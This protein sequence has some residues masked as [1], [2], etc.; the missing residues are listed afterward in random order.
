[1]TYQIID[2]RYYF[3]TDAGTNILV[4]NNRGKFTKEYQ[5][6]LHREV[7]NFIP[8][9]LNVIYDRSHHLKGKFYKK[10]EVYSKKGDFKV[11][12]TNLGIKNEKNIL[13]KKTLSKLEYSKLDSYTANVKTRHNL[14]SQ[15]ASFEFK[16]ALTVGLKKYKNKPIQIIVT[17]QNNPKQMIEMTI[18]ND[19][20][21]DQTYK[22][23][24]NNVFGGDSTYFYEGGPETLIQFFELK[25]LKKIPKNAQ[26]KNILYQ[27][28]K[29][30]PDKHC[31]I[32][33]IK[34]YFVERINN[35]CSKKVI[36]NLTNKINKIKNYEE[37]YADGIPEDHIQKFVDDL[38]INIKINLPLQTSF[39]EFRNNNTTKTI[40]NFE[41]VNL[42][43]NHVD[44]L[45][46][47]NKI[48]IVDRETLIKLKDKLVSENNYFEIKKDSLG[49]TAIV[50][51]N[52]TYQIDNDFKEAMEEFEEDNNIKPC[53]L[54]NIKDKEV[55]KFIRES[56][57]YA[58]RMEFYEAPLLKLE[59]VPDE[60]FLDPNYDFEEAFMESKRKFIKDSVLLQIDQKKSYASYKQCKYFDGVLGKPTDWRKTDKVEGVGSYR[61]KNIDLSNTDSKSKEIFEKLNWFYKEDPVYDSI[62]LKLLD[63]ENVK[64]DI[65]EGCWG[66]AIDIIFTKD[67]LEKK[68][69]LGYNS[70]GTERKVS[71]YAKLCGLYNNDKTYETKIVCC[72]IKI[73]QILVNNLNEMNIDNNGYNET[74]NELYIF[75]PKNIRHHF[76]QF[77]AKVTACT[78]VNT[79]VQLKEMDLS[80]VYKISSDA[81]YYQK[82]D[83]KI[84]EPYRPKDIIIST[85]P[86]IGGAPCK[87]YLSWNEET[88]TEAPPSRPYY[89]TELHIGQGGGGKTTK[90]LLDKGLV[91][92]LYIAP[93]WKLACDKK[94]EF[95]CNVA[96]LQHLFSKNKQVIL[97]I[98]QY[99]NV[100]IID[101]I[102]QLTNKQKEHILKEYPNH[103]II[104]CGDI[105]K[106]G[107]NYQL[108]PFE[109]GDSEIKCMNVEKI[110]NIVEHSTNYRV[111][112]K[113]LENILLKLREMIQNGKSRWEMISYVEQIFKEHNKIIDKDKLKKLYNIEDMIISGTK[114]N[115]KEISE[116]FKG[117]FDKE[118]YY[119]TKTE[120]NAK[121]NGN[122]YCKGE[123][124]ISEDPLP[125]NISKISH[126]FTLH[127]LQGETAKNKLFIDLRKIECFD[128]TFIYTALSR[129]RKFKD[130]YLINEDAING[131]C[132]IHGKI[133]KISNGIDNYVGSTKQKTIYNRLADH[134][135]NYDNM[136]N[137]KPYD[138]CTVFKVLEKGDYDITLLEEYWCD[139]ESELILK[140]Y[141]YIQQI[142][143]VNKNGKVDEVPFI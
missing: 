26:N 108:P 51:P 139:T 101:E 85:G 120:K 106:E 122:G 91:R 66:D 100:L 141:E 3:T 7:I 109:K 38:N 88:A 14:T 63:A 42:R 132:K 59:D 138:K 133:Y 2:K 83:F 87:S 130:I 58:G 103:K 44:Y 1:M 36:D 11:K 12:F 35:S 9:S 92:P 69:F 65:Y 80:K 13:V 23:I 105:S 29:D 24:Y 94:K 102:S 71:Y 52:I 140:E 33:P 27:S 126:C 73:A 8:S 20:S 40:K 76:S 123:I 107:I 137:N 18:L 30:S 32:Q 34:D 53:K 79:F 54:C 67:M 125:E 82:H 81:I 95:N 114:L 21:L 75:I 124:H 96:V 46:S 98:N 61:I 64:Y 131:S 89:K 15:N 104:F 134:I 25:S 119:I 90:N 143:C 110:D 70:D 39:L 55:S 49:I 68:E 41:Y 31:L 113:R 135:K 19:K 97:D 118:K 56:V 60:S 78:R 6:A 45:E 77:T 112:C 4:R 48:E 17:N 22:Q 129:A 142:D 74:T 50:R 16:N 72:D 99:Y 37:T 115:S 84:V 117:K 43:F 111:K 28:F 5:D 10:D 86:T 136:I 128:K 121:L 57:H 127:S 62:D 47:T 93:S 116:M